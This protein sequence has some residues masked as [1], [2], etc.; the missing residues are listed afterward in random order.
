M[1]VTAAVARAYA[2]LKSA[3]VRRAKAGR[4]DIGQTY[5]PGRRLRRTGEPQHRRL[6]RGVEARAAETFE[7]V[8]SDAEWRAALSPAQY[9]VLRL[10]RTEWAGSS[11]LDRERR[12]GTFRCAGCDLPLFSSAAKF[13]SGTGWPSFTSALAGA[14][15]TRVDHGLF[16]REM[17]VHCRRCGGH[18]GHVFDD[19]PAPTGKRFCINGAALLFAAA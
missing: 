15:R 10:S 2:V 16:G 19:G 5:I 17:E 9:A 8:K 12:R 13:D 1:S 4:C 18:L 7:V 14:V 3:R 6:R 11:P